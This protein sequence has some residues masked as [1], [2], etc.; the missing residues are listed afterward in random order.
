MITPSKRELIAI[1]S[2]HTINQDPLLL[3]EIVV[4]FYKSYTEED[5]IQFWIDY[6]FLEDQQERDW[7]FK[8]QQGA[9]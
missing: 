4:D 5:L 3:N 9:L 6:G 8:E 7:M 2:E 1:L